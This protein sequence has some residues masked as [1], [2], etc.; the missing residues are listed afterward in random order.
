MEWNDESFDKEKEDVWKSD[1]V[2]LEWIY[3]MKE[4][5]IITLSMSTV[6]EYIQR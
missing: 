4:N 6:E 1:T 3:K 5:C 2:Y